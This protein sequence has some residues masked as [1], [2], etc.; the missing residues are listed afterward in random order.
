MSPLATTTTIQCY[1]SL[2]PHKATLEMINKKQKL[3]IPLLPATTKWHVQTFRWA[4]FPKIARTDNGTEVLVMWR[5]LDERKNEY[6]KRAIVDA[7][8]WSIEAVM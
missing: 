5:D 1:W 6:I 4:H 8:A 2:A 3:K 7:V